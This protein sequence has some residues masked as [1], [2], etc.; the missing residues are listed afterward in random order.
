MEP[1]EEALESATI[2]ESSMA[3]RDFAI[4]HNML[5][6]TEGIYPTCRA[7]KLLRYLHNHIKCTPDSQPLEESQINKKAACSETR[8]SKNCVEDVLPNGEPPAKK[9]RVAPNTIPDLKHENQHENLIPKEENLIEIEEIILPEVFINCVE[10]PDTIPALKHENQDAGGRTIFS[11]GCTEE[12][13]ERNQFSSDKRG[14]YQRDCGEHSGYNIVCSLLDQAKEI[15][16]TS[17][18]EDILKY[19]TTQLKTKPGCQPLTGSDV[20][21]GPSRSERRPTEIC[22][23]DNTHVKTRETMKAQDPIKLELFTAPSP[24]QSASFMSRSNKGQLTKGN[25]KV[26][27]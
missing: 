17:N 24:S 26:V 14:G 16:A 13:S 6:Q 19:I 21:M 25:D 12:R 27:G 18:A 2:A 23:E 1:L 8:P 10:G 22:R 9:P 20:N 7:K 11:G 15:L 4:A 3:R 5:N